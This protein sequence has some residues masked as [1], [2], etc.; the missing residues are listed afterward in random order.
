MGRSFYLYPRKTGVIYAEIMNPQTGERI[1]SRSTGTSN[2]DE[3]VLTVGQWLRD[4]IPTRHRKTLQ[5]VGAV[6]GLK[7]ILRA[8][9][10]T[11]D[12]DAEGALQIT[13]TLRRMGLV[14]FNV[15]KAGKGSRD[16]IEYLKEFWDW[17]RSPYIREKVGR[18]YKLG[19][20]H[21]RESWNRIK[22]NW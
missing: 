11:P 12:L 17:D 21:A 1:A 18:G 10:K 14:T 5:T 13:E 6:G 19:K 9:E 15:V 2:R 7:N 16:F 22:R 4:G 3:A 8:I 20:R